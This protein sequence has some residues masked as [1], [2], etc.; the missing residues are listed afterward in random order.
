MRN[1]RPVRVLLCAFTVAAAVMLEPAVMV[2]EEFPA[3]SAAENDIQTTLPLAEDS[4]EDDTQGAPGTG[5]LQLPEEEAMSLAAV[6]ADTES[7]TGILQIP[8][9]DISVNL[10]S[11]GFHTKDNSQQIV[12]QPDSA[13][14]CTRFDHP[15]IADHDSQNNFSSIQNALGQQAYLILYSEGSDTAAYTKEETDQCPF[16]TLTYNCIGVYHGTNTGSDIRI[17]SYSALKDPVGDLVIYTCNGSWQN[18][19]VTIWQY[20]MPENGNAKASCVAPDQSF[21]P[22][23]I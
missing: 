19:W 13:A 9:E 8:E 21:I 3:D 18:V 22:C 16:L 11:C 17:G 20:V 6:P 2:K 15:V 7:S 5:M 1:R 14:Y 4:A 10:Y 23:R 12:D